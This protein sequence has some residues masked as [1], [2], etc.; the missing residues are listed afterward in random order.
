M[1]KKNPCQGDVCD[2]STGSIQGRR[3]ASVNKK[4]SSMAGDGVT[5]RATVESW[6]W[7]IVQ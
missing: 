7:A 3:H 4:T 6:L 1:I 2:R 5:A